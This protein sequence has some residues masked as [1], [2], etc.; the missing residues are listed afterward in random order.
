MKK[1]LF[2]LFGATLFAWS[3]LVGAADPGKVEF[4]GIP[5]GASQETL[6]KA[7]PDFKCSEGTCNLYVDLETAQKC[8]ENKNRDPKDIVDV[9]KSLDCE[10]YYRDVMRYGPAVVQVYVAKFEN[11]RLG[12]VSVIFNS[13]WYQEVRGALIEKYGAQATERIETI[14]NRFGQNFEN[15]LAT[16]QLGSDFV[17]LEE[18]AADTDTAAVRLVAGSFTGV[19]QDRLRRER[20]REAARNL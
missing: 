12:Y 10:R 11:N 14:Q 20:A 16:W 15:H 19:D 7:F 13:T 6:L 8:A 17:Q 18:R 3:L 9:K 5:F 2:A 1:T 4:K